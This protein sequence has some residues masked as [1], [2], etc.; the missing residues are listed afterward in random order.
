MRV[1]VVSSADHVWIVIYRHHIS[2]FSYFCGKWTD[3]AADNTEPEGKAQEQI[4]LFSLSLS[5]NS[6]C[7]I[8]QSCGCVWYPVLSMPAHWSLLDVSVWSSEVRKEIT[9]FPSLLCMNKNWSVHSISRNQAGDEWTPRQA[10]TDTSSGFPIENVDSD[11]GFLSS[12]FPSNFSVYLVLSRLSPCFTLQTKCNSSSF[13]ETGDTSE[14][15]ILTTKWQN[16]SQ[17]LSTL[18]W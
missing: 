10:V 15:I 8:I 16:I 9:C 5:F 11:S 18:S 4:M 7:D 3:K 6:Y 17:N 14:C 1:G 12:I 2:V 13:K